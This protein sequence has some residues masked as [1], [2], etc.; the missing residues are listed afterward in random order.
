MTNAFPYIAN[1][2]WAIIYDNGGTI[3]E[4]QK[5]SDFQEALKAAQIRIPSYLIA[6]PNNRQGIEEYNPVY[7]LKRGVIKEISKFESAYLKANSTQPLQNWVDSLTPNAFNDLYGDD[8]FKF[9]TQQA[10][11]KMETIQGDAIDD[12]FFDSLVNRFDKGFPLTSE[13]IDDMSV[14]DKLFGE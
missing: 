2:P 10:E 11:E 9:S 13:A 12:S 4:I 3:R 7:S 14:M 6:G 1:L 8:I 5:L